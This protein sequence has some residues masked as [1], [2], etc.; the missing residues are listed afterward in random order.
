P[1]RHRRSA[2]GQTR[3]PDRASRGH[4][5]LARVH[6]N[7]PAVQYRNGAAASAEERQDRQEVSKRF[8]Y[9]SQQ[10]K[11]L[12]LVLTCKDTAW[13]GVQQVGPKRR[14]NHGNVTRV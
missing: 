2:P 9:S 7:R 12:I 14:K 8:A 13:T 6:A 11:G 3:E 10:L 5:R 1:C 4:G